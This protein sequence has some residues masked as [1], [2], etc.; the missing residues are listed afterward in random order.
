MFPHKKAPKRKVWCAKNTFGN[1]PA[2]ACLADDLNQLD[3][4]KLTADVSRFFH[5]TCKRYKD[6]SSLQ[7]KELLLK[8]IT[9]HFFAGI[10]SKKWPPNIGSFL[11][12]CLWVQFNKHLKR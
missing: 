4:P 7:D 6:V 3:N 12:N 11:K 5:T 1:N 2:A 8:L 10:D 9:K